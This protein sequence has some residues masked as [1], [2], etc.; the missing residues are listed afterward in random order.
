MYHA[1]YRKYRPQTFDDVVGQNVIVQTL[2]NSIKNHSFSHAYMFFGPRGTGKTTISKIFA[3][4]V[5]CLDSHDGNL[6][7]KCKNCLASFDKEC[8]DIIEIDAASN[9]GVNE[10]RELKNKISLVPSQ[11]KYKI[12]I[13]DEVHML[14][15]EAFNALLK[16][17]EE[18]PEH[19]IF[20]LATT[21]QQKVPETII[22]RCQCFSFNR[23]SEN[24]I[25]S[26]LDYVCKQESIKID[27]DVLDEIAIFCDGGMRDALGMLD[28]LHSY[29]SEQITVED[30]SK[31]NNMAQKKDLT[32]LYKI[33]FSG[34]ISSLILFLNKMDELGKNMVQVMMQFMYF[35][36]KLVVDYYISSKKL[37]YSL[38]EIQK[39][40]NL[41]NEK[42]FDIQKSGN[43]RIYIEILLLTFIQNSIISQKNISREI[44]STPEKEND[45]EKQLNLDQ[46]VSMETEPLDENTKED[47][48]SSLE[49]KEILS[50]S[51]PRIINLDEIMKV[52]VN[53]TL[54]EADKTVLKKVIDAMEL[55]K[56]Y[57]FDTEIG[58]IVCN[59]LDS[60]VR[61]ASEKN[62]I[63]SYEYDSIVKQ[64]LLNLNQMVNVYH[65]IT[66]LTQNIAIISD[67]EW[68]KERI[69][70]INSI[71][72]NKH[73]VIVEE[74]EI[75]LESQ[76]KNDIISNNAV[77][78]F[79]DIVEVE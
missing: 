47:N 40:I 54:A 56:D 43:P 62:I 67:E 48:I 12:Y 13:I 49:K 66:K 58:Y 25:K 45:I 63:I 33:I 34:N 73:Y 68:E 21:D 31:L 15:I 52:R 2:K 30:F 77:E 29:T 9:N 14:S 28:K 57:T 5:N 41:I 1:L 51:T 36:R 59:L 6:C 7:G 11:L 42:M 20:V 23:I 74:P 76:Q 22:S 79:G 61:A 16:T 10:I 53:N 24:M 38:V 17:L 50:D 69:K 27:E 4:T 8:V 39:L 19:A 55:L 18:P 44:I 46:K 75:I 60:K 37:E 32:E 71:K 3:R 70:Y 65:K 26:R 78:L 64:N 72:N 35:L